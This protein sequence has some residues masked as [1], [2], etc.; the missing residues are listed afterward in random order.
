MYLQ[1]D[2]LEVKQMKRF[3]KKV[4]DWFKKEGW[5]YWKPTNQCLRL[6]EEVGE[7]SRVVNDLFGEKPKKQGEA[8]Q[9]LALEIGDVIYTCICLANSQ[10]I[11][12]DQAV[13]ASIDKVTKRDKNRY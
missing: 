2:V 12:L 11:D 13:Q 6:A 10:K 1:Y 7:V 4:D 3:Q 9:D 8:K 5:K